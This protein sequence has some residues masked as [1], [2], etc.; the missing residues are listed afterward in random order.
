M[1]EIFLIARRDYLAVVS[2]WGFWLSLCTA[3]LLFAVVVFAPVLLSRSEPARALVIAAD[4]PADEAA[5]IAAFDQAD[6]AS[7]REALS[8]YLAAAAP[9]AQAEALAAF[10][11]AATTAQGAAAARAILA[12][13]APAATQAMPQPQQ[14]YVIAQAPARDIEGLRPYLN[15]ERQITIA[16]RQTPLFGAIL[17]TRSDNGVRLA[18][19]SANLTDPTPRRRAE[20]ALTDILRS[21]AL[22]ARGVDAQ[23]A[24]RI[25]ALAPEVEQFDP[26]RA[27]RDGAVTIRDRAPYIVAIVMAFVL[28]SA[29]FGVANMLLTSVLEEKSNKILDTLLTSASPLQILIGKL[30]GTAAVSATLFGVWGLLGGSLARFAAGRAPDGLMAGIAGAAVDPMLIGTFLACFV[31]GYLMYGAL[32]LA[33]GSLCET[34]QEAQT[35]LGP[36]IFVLIIPIILLGP[37]FDNPK[38]PFFAYASWVPPLTPFLM[39]VRAPAGL[40]PAEIAGP[41]ITLFVA[42]GFILW[43]AAR[44]FHAGVVDNATAASL[45]NRVLRRAEQ[46]PASS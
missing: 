22:A 9:G 31:A 4:R 13:R 33:L 28:W 37:A 19:W 24:A 27:Q 20:R 35:L 3:P 17:I 7:A 6:R 34:I 2:A 41:F 40:S 25:D 30:A 42:V 32:F 44:V 43:G 12:A 38:A 11:A 23:E 16:G 39:M 10:D 18:Y 26:R 8:A 36:V 45:R 5:V 46:R 1:R 14:R 15:G 29:V 21:E